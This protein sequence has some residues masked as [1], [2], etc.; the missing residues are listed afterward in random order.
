M[1]FRYWIYTNNLRLVS[2]STAN[3]LSMEQFYTDYVYDYGVIYKI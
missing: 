3:G 2:D 1:E